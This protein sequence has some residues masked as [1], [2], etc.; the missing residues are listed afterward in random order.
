MICTPQLSI[1]DLK[2]NGHYASLSAMFSLLQCYKQRT[3]LEVP[4]QSIQLPCKI[5]MI[6][7]Y[8]HKEAMH[9]ATM[10][11]RLGCQ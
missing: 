10:N 4:L 7:V 6:P 9:H 2:V 3:V 5:Q 8:K 11:Q 1:T